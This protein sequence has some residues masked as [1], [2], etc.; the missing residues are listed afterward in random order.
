M[1]R[2]PEVHEDLRRLDISKAYIFER[3]I[4]RDFQNRVDYC[5]RWAEDIGLHVGDEFV[6][7]RDEAMMERP[8]VLLA[9]IDECRLDGA[10]LV[11][12]DLNGLSVEPRTLFTIMLELREPTS[13]LPDG[14]PLL[15]AGT[16]VVELPC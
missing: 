8:P 6:A 11:V 13:N 14:V 16:G 5:Y 10:A 1:L 2:Q 9:A 15:V 4:E 7:A 3:A 12:Y